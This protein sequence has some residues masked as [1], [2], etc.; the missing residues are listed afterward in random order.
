MITETEQSALAKIAFDAADD[1]ES[2]SMDAG[3]IEPITV[4][5]VI[6]GYR[7]IGRQIEAWGKEK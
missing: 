1:L 3:G 4:D 5:Q 6:N 7:A 2:R